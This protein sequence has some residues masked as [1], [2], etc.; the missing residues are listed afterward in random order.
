[1]E[2][3]YQEYKYVLQDT[4][5]LYLGAKYTYDEI[6]EKKEVPFKLKA[7]VE[8]YIKPELN[9]QG[10][11]TGISLEDYFYEIKPTG[12][13]YQAFKQLKLRVRVVLP[14][15]ARTFSGKEK[16]KFNTQIYKL[17]QL[18]ALS[19]Q[20]KEEKGIIIQEIIVSKIAL[21]TFGL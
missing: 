19:P 8:R 7:F 21:L 6:M 9:N 18:T 15:K 20:E 16:I 3:I 13:A 10:L 1:M 12:F 5:H 11:G 14:V 4:S 2:S 17:E